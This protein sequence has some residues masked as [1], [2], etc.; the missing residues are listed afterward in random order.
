MRIDAL[1]RSDDREVAGLAAKID[2]EE[3]Y[4]RIHA[5][6]WVGRLLGEAGGRSR[7]EEATSSISGRTRS[8]FRPRRH[9]TE[10]VE[11]VRER[12]PFDLPEGERSSNGAGTRTSYGPLWE[13]MTRCGERA[14]RGLVTLEAVWDCPRRHPDPEIPVV[15]LVDLGVIRD[16]E[17]A[18]GDVRIEFTPTFLGCPALEVMKAAMEERVRELGAEPHVDVVL[19][20]SW[21]TDRITPEGREKLRAAGFAP[22]A[23]RSQERRSSCSSRAR[24]S[25]ARTAARP[26]RRSRT[27]SARRRA[28]RSGTATPA[29]SRSS[30]SRRSSLRPRRSRFRAGLGGPPPDLVPVFVPAPPYRSTPRSTMPHVRSAL[31]FRR[32]AVIAAPVLSALLIVAGFFLDP[33]IDESGREPAREYRT[34]PRA[35]IA[36]AFHFAFAFRCPGRRP[37]RRRPRASLLANLAAL[38]LGMTTLPGFLLTDF[39]DIAIYGELGGDAWDAVDDRIQEPP[40]GGDHVPDRLPRFLLTLPVALLA[41]WRAGLLPWWPALVVLAGSVAARAI[42]GGFGLLV[43]AGALLVLGYVLWRFP[44]EPTATPSPSAVSAQAPNEGD[45][46]G[47]DHPVASATS[48]RR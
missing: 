17:I 5:E 9:R 11:R 8:A 22:P 28:A 47:P 32:A 2:R 48:P 31:G 15:S 30:S 23:P 33:A 10:F 1:K 34:P 45:T 14:W 7:L 44:A 16:V 29:G 24:P 38:P 46:N 36:L 12:L 6:M 26:I 25:A 21:S 20:D 13:E 18:D 43:W 37:D 27:S 40:G 19:D 3:V 42:P 41:A 4:H 39:Y 35:G